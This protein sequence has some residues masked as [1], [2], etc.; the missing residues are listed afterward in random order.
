MADHGVLPG[1]L[2]VTKLIDDSG[3]V[4]VAAPVDNR[5]DAEKVAV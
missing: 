1:E 4:E 2:R 3:F 5:V